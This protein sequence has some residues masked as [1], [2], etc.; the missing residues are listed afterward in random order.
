M[1]SHNMQKEIQHELDE[2]RQSH[3]KVKALHEWKKLKDSEK[4]PGWPP[5]FQIYDSAEADL[6]IEVNYFVSRA[7]E[8]HQVLDK[9]CEDWAIVTRNELIS[10][11][12]EIA[13]ITAAK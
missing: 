7:M 9:R 8:L 10:M 2:I 6:Q 3:E 11:E 1:L 13:V 4:K 5:A 12:R